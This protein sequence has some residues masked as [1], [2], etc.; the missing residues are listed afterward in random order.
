MATPKPKR[1]ESYQLVLDALIEYSK[2][3]INR[4]SGAMPI[5]AISIV[6]FMDR[7]GKYWFA[8][9][10]DGSTPRWRKIGLLYHALDELSLE[11]EGEEDET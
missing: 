8:I 1:K 4:R 11:P 3:S 9:I 7:N 2:R 5:S 6:E 10:D